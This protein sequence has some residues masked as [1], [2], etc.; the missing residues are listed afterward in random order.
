MKISGMVLAGCVLLGGCS[1]QNAAEP[2][3][4]T[5]AL[6]MGVQ[7]VSVT[8]CDEEPAKGGL[9]IK[10]VAANEYIVEFASYLACS[11]DLG[12]AYLTTAKE[13]K[14][15]LVVGSVAKDGCECAKS[16]SLKISDRLESGEVLYVLTGAEVIGHMLVP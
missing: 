15:T 4:S 2:D 5:F 3:K 16:V 13:G 12:K 9:N 8:K 14:S 10:K 7:V 11:G 1:K 6:T